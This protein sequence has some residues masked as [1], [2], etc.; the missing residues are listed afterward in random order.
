MR[1]RH[2]RAFL[3]CLTQSP[4]SFPLLRCAL[5]CLL[6]EPAHV[7]IDMAEAFNNVGNHLVSDSA[8]A[9]NAGA[10]DLSTI[11]AN[12]SALARDVA[13]G[14]ARR[15][16]DDDDEDVD[17]Y[18]DDD[19]ESLISQPVNGAKGKVVPKAEEDVELPPHAC[20]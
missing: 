10:D 4:N 19:L 18:D 20:A 9:I 6:T 12:D 2:L 17:L 15:R 3:F 7:A 1:E 13:S 5:P 14:R 11:D 16:R 8:A